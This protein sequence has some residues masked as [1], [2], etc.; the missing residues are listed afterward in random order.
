MD[1]ASSLAIAHVFKQ[2]QCEWVAHCVN[3]HI[4]TQLHGSWLENNNST[5]E[6]NEQ[7]V[8]IPGTNLN[9]ASKPT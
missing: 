2:R 3:E 7:E 4:C 1:V 9:S 5:T 8:N 6:W